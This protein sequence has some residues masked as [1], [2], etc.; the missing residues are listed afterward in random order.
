MMAERLYGIGFLVISGHCLW[1]LFSRLNGDNFHTPLLMRIRF[2]ELRGA[3]YTA[4]DA[5]QN[6]NFLHKTTGG[7][8]AL[9]VCYL[10]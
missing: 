9:G 5:K 10:N 1:P 8:F 7:S 3:N 4:V 6:W 2:K